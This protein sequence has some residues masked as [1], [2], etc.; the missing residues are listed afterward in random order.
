[1][2]QWDEVDCYL[3]HSRKEGIL[4]HLIFWNGEE[5]WWEMIEL[6]SCVGSSHTLQL[7]HSILGLIYV[8]V[9][10]I[11]RNSYQVDIK[12]KK[13]KTSFLNW[14]CKDTCSHCPLYAACTSPCDC[15]QPLKDV[16]SKYKLLSSFGYQLWIEMI[17]FQ[18]M[19]LLSGI[20]KSLYLIVFLM[21]NFD[22]LIV[23]WK[24]L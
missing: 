6:N 19:E 18:P 20:H 14:K 10:N 22:F 9:H 4:F 15:I 17:F 21:A 24:V 7:K 8:S 23:D 2:S 11:E 13:G 1:M 12:D 16:K 3:G 5:M